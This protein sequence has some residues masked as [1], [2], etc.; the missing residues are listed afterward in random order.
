MPRLHKY[1]F[2]PR[3]KQKINAHQNHE[4]RQ[5]ELD[6]HLEANAALILPFRKSLHRNTDPCGA[7]S[8]RYQR[9][10]IQQGSYDLAAGEASPAEAGHRPSTHLGRGEGT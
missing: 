9:L 7:H 8:L 5:D 4:L 10:H 1:D 6:A 3:S 2:V